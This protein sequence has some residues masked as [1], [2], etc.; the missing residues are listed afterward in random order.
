MVSED[1]EHRG[2]GTAHGGVQGPQLPEA[3]LDTEDFSVFRRQNLLENVAKPCRHTLQVPGGQGLCHTA[4]IRPGRQLRPVYPG[5]QRWRGDAEIRLAEDKGAGRQGRQVRQHLAPALRQDGAAP[6][7]EGHVTAYRQANALQLPVLHRGT[8]AVPQQPQQSRHVGAAA[9]HA[10]VGRCPLVQRH[11]KAGHGKAGNTEK[12][13]RRLL[14]QGLF[15]RRNEIAVG[16]EKKALRRL[17]HRHGV[18]EG[19][20]LH[21]HPH[22]VVSVLPASQNVQRQVH[23]GRRVPLH[24]HHTFLHEKHPTAS[25]WHSPRH[26]SHRSSA[27]AASA[28]RH[29]A[30]AYA[31]R[32]PPAT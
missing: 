7:A 22:L 13:L 31:A 12:A 29:S 15:S 25:T 28:S 8:V 30:E 17:L 10:G 23:L 9:A 21:H 24:F 26:T 11:G 14:L 2:P 18:A 6:D 32:C 5:K 19:H 27:A 1:A 20:R 3:I 16:T 4:D